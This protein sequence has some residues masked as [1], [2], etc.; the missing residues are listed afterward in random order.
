MIYEVIKKVRLENLTILTPHY[1]FDAAALF[2]LY[3]IYF[4]ARSDK[5]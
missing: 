5:T 4:L 1:S 3:P 2:I